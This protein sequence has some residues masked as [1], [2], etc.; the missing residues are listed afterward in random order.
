M[1][2]FFSPRPVSV[3]HTTSLVLG[4]SLT[5]RNGPASRLSSSSRVRRL[6]PRHGLQHRRWQPA[7]A[8]H[9]EEIQGRNMWL[10]WTGGDDRLWDT[11]TVSSLGSFDLLKT[12]S[13]HP[14][15]KGAPTAPATAVTIAGTT[16]GWSTSRAS[17]RRQVPTRIT[18]AC[19]SIRD[20]SCPPDPFAD[21]VKY[22][23]VKIGARG[24]TVPVGLLLRR[25]DRR[26]RTS[27]VSESGVRR[28]RRER[29]GIRFASTPTR[30]TTTR[31]D[32][33]RPYRV[34]MSC[35]VCHVG[36]NPIRPPADPENPKWENLS[37]NV[38]SQ[39]SWWDRIFNWRGDS[40]RT[41]SSIRR[42][43]RIGP[44]RWI[45]RWCRRTTSTTR[46]R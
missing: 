6:L 25:A 44:A 17:R 16:S 19:G 13:S 29:N 36:P 24:K 26:G 39:Y 18:S 5:K 2:R 3:V 12:I 20:P 28:E 38:G 34:G 1:R 30:A 15:P 41:A 21:P 40:D 46:G 10:V 8:V 4:R 45:P 32:L 42:S 43:T 31:R 9:A 23:G 7:P 35:G 22:P 33:V 14:D 11:L 37:S 27:A